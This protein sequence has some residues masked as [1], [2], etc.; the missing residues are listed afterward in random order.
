MDH[1]HRCKSQNIVKGIITNW[2]HSM[3]A[4]TPIFRPNEM[5]FFAVTIEGGLEIERD[6]HACLDCGLVWTATDRTRLNEFIERN[7]KKS[8]P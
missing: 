5:R 6:V 7:C 1:C 3:A 2:G 8:S 4:S